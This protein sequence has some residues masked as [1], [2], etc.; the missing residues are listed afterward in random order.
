MVYKRL[1]IVKRLIDR[2]LRR[3]M[4]FADGVGVRPVHLTF[5]SALCGFIGVYFVFERGIL[6]AVLVLSYVVL[7][8]LDGTLARV[9]GRSSEFGAKLDFLVDRMVAFLFLVKYYFY[10]N[11][12]VFPFVGIFA[13]LAVSATEDDV[14]LLRWPNAL[15]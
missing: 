9:S 14:K 12:I 4:L 1:K 15:R 11:S 10:T 2:A 8:V 3:P 5:I 6:S 7:D 13:I